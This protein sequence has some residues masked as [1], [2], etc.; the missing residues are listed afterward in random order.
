MKSNY[1]TL[2]NCT[3]L[4]T[5]Y[6]GLYSER[7]L[8]WRTETDLDFVAKGDY[9]KSKQAINIE[10]NSVHQ[11]SK[12]MRTEEENIFLSTSCSAG[13]EAFL[14]KIPKDYHF[15]L[16]NDDYPSIT[17]MVTDHQ[18]KFSEVSMSSTLESSVLEELR[19]R[20]YQVLLFS[21]V[22][23]NSGLL[24]DMNFIEEI[25][26]EFPEL[27]ILVDGTQYIGNQP[28]DFNRSL[29]DG[30][31]VS[32]YKW[33][34]AGHGNGFLCLKKSLLN[35]L[36]IS[37]I[38]VFNLLDRGHRAPIAMGSLGFA[39]EELMSYDLDVVFQKNKELG[40]YLFEALKKRN[41]LEDFISERKKHST[42]FTIKVNKALFE[43]LKKNNIRCIQRGSGVRIAVHFYNTKAEVDF[44]LQVLD[45]AVK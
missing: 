31:F 5:A 11:L 39:V 26:N 28:F 27:I 30:I 40:N 20:P 14:L 4:N 9:F 13:L 2:E 32:G 16:L 38:D 37:A 12:L 36:K 29:I 23:Y 45:K 1:P 44:F 22:Q 18:F 41:L 35:R 6:C 34:L 19:N 7:L 10:K 43:I 25:K 8:Q 24:F 15:L 42:I 17:E 3:Y 33:L 21:A